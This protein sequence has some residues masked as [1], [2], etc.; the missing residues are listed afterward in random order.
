VSC[1]GWRPGEV[2]DM[3]SDLQTMILTCF[4]SAF[5]Q[6]A[7]RREVGG[8]RKMEQEQTEVAEFFLRGLLPLVERPRAGSE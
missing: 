2:F 7:A 6:G 1:R 4:P 3:K 8:N 5:I